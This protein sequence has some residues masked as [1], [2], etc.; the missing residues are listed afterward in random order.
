MPKFSI[1]VEARIAKT[2]EVE[3]VDKW[4]AMDQAHLQFNCDPETSESYAQEVVHI[5][6]MKEESK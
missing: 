1:T 6:L 4:E 5:Q 3:A 2:F